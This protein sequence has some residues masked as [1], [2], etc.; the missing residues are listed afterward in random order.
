MTTIL[1]VEDDAELRAALHETLEEAG[2]RVLAASGGHA[3]LDIIGREPVDA[4]VTDIVMA[5]GEG[6]EFIMKAKA[7]KPSLPVIAMSAKALYL[8]DAASLGADHTLQKPFRLR[9][10]LTLLGPAA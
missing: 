7:A 1:V 3:A 9:D 8:R 10:L 5:D 6:I 2:F 4:A